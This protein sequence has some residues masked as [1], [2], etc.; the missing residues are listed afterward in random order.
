MKPVLVKSEFLDTRPYPISNDVLY[1]AVCRLLWRLEDTVN[2]PYDT[3]ETT[4]RLI[5]SM[6]AFLLKGRLN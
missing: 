2:L 4:K 1:E 6:D 3:S 5:K